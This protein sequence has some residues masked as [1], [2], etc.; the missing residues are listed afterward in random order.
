MTPAPAPPADPSPG[1]A[2]DD[3][4]T[5]RDRPDGL[6]FSGNDA[7]FDW[8]VGFL[9]SVRAHNPSLPLA[10]IPFD[11]RCDRLHALAG[12]YD[13]RVFEDPAFGRLEAIGESLELGLTS[14]GPRWFRRYAAFWGPFGR[15]LYLDCRQ[16]ALCDL[17]ELIAA[18]ATHGFDLL[19]FDCA[20]DQVYE[21]GPLRSGFLRAGRGR[22]FLSG[23]WASRRGLFSLEDLERHAADCLKVRDELNARNTDQAF[24]NYCCDAGTVAE[25][26][27]SRPIRTGHFAEVLGDC[28]RDAWARQPGRAVR[29]AAGVYRRWDHGGIDHGKRIPI[30]HWA[31][32]GLSPAMP[33]AELFFSYRNRSE[34][35]SRRAAAAATHAAARP[36]LRTADR[37]RRNRAINTL[38]HRLRG[39][40]R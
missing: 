38:W 23:L 5:G 32:M 27:G 4:E 11:G 28:C 39:D 30:L 29:D 3:R 20:I 1:P 14:Y 37:L 22:G 24:L 25:G 8:A 6:L 16:L 13:F 34:S 15:F 7:V 36:V 19:H 35:R 26:D 10:L 33:E 12:R 17:R 21:P 18:P 9:E 31:G 40:G 2:D